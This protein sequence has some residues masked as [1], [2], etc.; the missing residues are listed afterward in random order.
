MSD[1]TSSLT[2]PAARTERAPS[3]RPYT[4]E[5]THWGYIVRATASAG[6]GIVVAQTMATV[7]GAIFLAAAI[8]LWLVPAAMFGTDAMFMRFFATVVFA[9]LAAM[10]LWYA[11]R[12]VKSE[13]QIDNSR[14]EIREVIRNK[15]GNQTLVGKYGFDAVSGVFL[16]D[17][18]DDDMFDLTLRYCSSGGSLV[19]A[20]GRE[21]HL[22]QLHDRIK[23]DV[24][25]GSGA[26]EQAKPKTVAAVETV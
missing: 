18:A 21:A 7:I 1:M 25:I 4:T 23:R 13:V 15:A 5:E 8:G 16:E 17:G 9:A 22:T 3:Q 6:R 10:L 14:G 2:T 19:L 24:L 26:S 12:G 20:S 11:S